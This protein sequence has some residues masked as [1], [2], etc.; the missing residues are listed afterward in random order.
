[1]R[2]LQ[3]APLWESV[4]PPAYGGTEYVVSL[5]TEELVKRGHDVTLAASGDSVTSAELI[6]SYG[7]SLRR[8]DDLSDRGPYEWQHL[9]TALR[10]AGDFDIIHNHSGEL[11]MALS[12]LVGPPMLTTM[13]CLPTTDNRFIWERY[14]GAYNT[15]SRS[16]H[17]HIAPFPGPA[18]FMGHVYNAVDVDTFPFEGAKG[19]DLLFMTW[20]NAGMRI[21]DISDHLLPREVGYFVPPVPTERRG[22]LPKKLVP[23]SEDVVVDARGCIYISDKNHGVYILRASDAVMAGRA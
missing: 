21:F 19:D 9:A 10:H 17:C 3:L 23:Q 15:I 20:F 5:I 2:I 7:R 16:Q 8:A 22:L 1:M 14:A 18:R 6:A 13:H 11:P 12:A 4:P